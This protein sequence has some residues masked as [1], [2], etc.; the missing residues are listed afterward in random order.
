MSLGADFN[1]PNIFVK[2]SARKEHSHH[3]RVGEILKKDIEVLGHAA[4]AAVRSGLEFVLTSRT[5]RSL[6]GI[7]NPELTPVT[8]ALIFD[9]SQER[10]VRRPETAPA[11]PE[12]PAEQPLVW[13]PDMEIN[14]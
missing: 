5:Y 2:S 13:N 3:A 11:Q 1:D 12:I 10:G 4:T 7:P 9:Y 14:L 8:N 6:V